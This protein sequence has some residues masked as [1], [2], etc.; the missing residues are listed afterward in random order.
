MKVFD[1]LAGTGIPKLQELTQK[2]FENFY[3]NLLKKNATILKLNVQ[4]YKKYK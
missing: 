1:S 4:G 2:N 3:N